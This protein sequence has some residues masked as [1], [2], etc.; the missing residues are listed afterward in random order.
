MVLRH[1]TVELTEKQYETLCRMTA[2]AGMPVADVIQAFAE[3]LP[4]NSALDGW[5]KQ[6]QRKN[7]LSYLAQKEKLDFV[8]SLFQKVIVYQ[9]NISAAYAKRKEKE[10][11][12]TVE[13]LETSWS[14]IQEIYASYAKENQAALPLLG[15]LQLLKEWR[16][17]ENKEKKTKHTR[18][19]YVDRI[20]IQRLIE[21]GCTKTEIAEKIGVHFSTI[22]R[23]IIRGGTPYSA[24]EAQRR[25]TGE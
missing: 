5:L 18:L 23:E 20:E 8:A 12:K 15:E 11:A 3:E 2:N 21:E 16:L 22:Y 9:A 19:K 14:L 25:L 13:Q 17:M 1:V 4:G 7:F 10:A 6:H 24:D